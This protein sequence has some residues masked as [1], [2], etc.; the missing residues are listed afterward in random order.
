[1][2]RLAKRYVNEIKPQL[3]K[4]LGITNPMAV[5][6]LSKVVVSMGTGSPMVDKNRLAAVQADLARI[7]GQRPQIRRA[8]R[9]VSNFKIRDGMEVGCRVTLR[10]RWMYEFLDRVIN[11]AIPRV[12]DFRGL[13]PRSFDGRGNYSMGLADQSIFPEID[14][15]KVTYNQG[16]NITLVTT[17]RNDSDARALLATLG[18]PFR[19]TDEQGN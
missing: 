12:R 18:M 1:M 3:G 6:R 5:P 14:V 15:S 4:E 7:T 9:S 19:K 13:N 10:G 11:V 8:R 17:A 16:M 2:A